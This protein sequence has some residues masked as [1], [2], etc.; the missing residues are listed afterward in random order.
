M[1]F[2][3]Q[4]HKIGQSRE[5][6]EIALAD[7][8]RQSLDARR[9]AAPNLGIDLR[10]VEDVDLAAEQVVQQHAARFVGVAGD[11]LGGRDGELGDALEHVLRRVRGEVGD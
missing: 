6:V 11:D 2:V 7:V 10:D 4:Q 1:G 8:L 5:G 9:F 3:H